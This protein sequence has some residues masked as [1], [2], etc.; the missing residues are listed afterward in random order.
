MFDGVR[1][2]LALMKFM[3]SIGPRLMMDA[4]NNDDRYEQLMREVTESSRIELTTQILPSA[5]DTL[6]ATGVLGMLEAKSILSDWLI[7]EEI[8]RFFN[9]LAA[10]A[11]M[12]SIYALLRANQVAI[13]VHFG[14]N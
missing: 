10:S 13:Q 6:A 4:F 5:L 14:P 11:I 12:P 1:T 7:K 3:M 2:R 9:R 8:I